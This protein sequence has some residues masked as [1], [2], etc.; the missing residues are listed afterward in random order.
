MSSSLRSSLPLQSCLLSQNK[1]ASASPEPTFMLEAALTPSKVLDCDNM[2]Q[3]Q[4]SPEVAR[5][6]ATTDIDTIDID[7]TDIDRGDRRTNARKNLAAIDR[8][9]PESIAS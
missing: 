6:F 5:L 2:L 4:A 9:Y 7:T 8:I 1:N 3:E